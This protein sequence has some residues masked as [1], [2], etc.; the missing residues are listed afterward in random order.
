MVIYN[1]SKLNDFKTLSFIIGI[2]I[3][4]FVHLANSG[5]IKNPTAD[6]ISPT[7]WIILPMPDLSKN[8]ELF[9]EF[10]EYRVAIIN[11]KNDNT[12]VYNQIS[13]LVSGKV[14]VLKPSLSNSLSRI[15]HFAKHVLVD[16]PDGDVTG[17]IRKYDSAILNIQ[18]RCPIYMDI[19][20]KSKVPTIVFPTNSINSSEFVSL[21]VNM[22]KRIKTLEKK[23]KKS[24]CDNCTIL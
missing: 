23:N 1:L 14:L 22:D 21:I 3:F 2:C 9:D 6:M 8:Q 13:L 16:A 15:D 19:Y 7:G 5:I 20:L 10:C 17:F 4:C 18:E 11:R 24:C 12:S